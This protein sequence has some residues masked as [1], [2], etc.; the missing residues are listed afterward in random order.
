LLSPLDPPSVPAND[1][2]PDSVVRV[3]VNAV[4]LVESATLL[5]SSGSREADT[6]ALDLAK[7]AAWEPLRYGRDERIAD[8]ASTFDWGR[9]VFS[10]HTVPLVTTNSPALPP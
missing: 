2:L 5:S 4:G 7:S 8:N 9:L 1:T 6:Q 3:M 10:W